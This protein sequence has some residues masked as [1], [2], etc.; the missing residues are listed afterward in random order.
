MKNFL[1]NL[2]YFLRSWFKQVFFLG[3]RRAVALMYHSI[4]LDNNFFS[5]RPEIFAKQIDYLKRNNYRVISLADLEKYLSAGAIP[6]KTVVITFDDGF[7]N[8]YFNAWPVLRRDNL[9]AAIFAAASLVGRSVETRNGAELPMLNYQELK[10][11]SQSGLITIG[12][13]GFSHKKLANLSDKEL[14]FE[15]ARG[16][17]ELAEKLGA[18]IDFLAF[19]FGSFNKQVESVAGKYYQLAFSTNPGTIGPND[20]LYALKRNSIDSR[21]SFYQFKHIVQYG[22]I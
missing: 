14:E 3:R 10:E 19:P 15:L 1:K 22:R 12:A 13:H 8:N 6:P 9:P 20:N 16:R 4:S 7:D 17:S 11:M 2:V 5:V 21:V 18:E